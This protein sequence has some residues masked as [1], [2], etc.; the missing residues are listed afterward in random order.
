M[1]GQYGNETVSVQNLPIVQILKEQNLILILGAIP[2]P[3]GAIVR[4]LQSVKKPNANSKFNI[5]TKE[6]QKQIQEQNVSLEDKD[7]L[8]IVNEQID[9]DNKE[10]GDKK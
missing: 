5:V 4:I 9:K 10:G 2:G 8:H 3:A 7:A 1:A 6:V